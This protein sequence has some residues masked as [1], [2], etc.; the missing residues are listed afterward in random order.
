MA[1]SDMK[2]E[3]LEVL[4]LSQSKSIPPGGSQRIIIEARA[5]IREAL[6]IYTLTLSDVDGARSL[7]LHDV[8]FPE[9]MPKP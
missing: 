9:I 2:P 4:D 1:T 6:G 5:T 7:T 3:E 8:T